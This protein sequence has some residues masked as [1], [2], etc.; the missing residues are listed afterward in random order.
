MPRLPAWL[1]AAAARMSR[2]PNRSARRRLALESL[3][4]REVPAAY[5]W[6]QTQ[7]G[8]FNWSDDANWDGDPG[9]PNAPGD[10]A[11]LGAAL[12]GNQVINF[13]T[14][15]TVGSLVVGSTGAGAYTIAGNG[16][17]LTFDGNGALATL[18]S[19]GTAGNAVLGPVVLASSLNVTNPD[20]DV[21]SIFGGITGTG[22]LSVTGPLALPN[23]ADLPAGITLAGTGP[24]TSPGVTYT[25]SFFD[26]AL[27]AFDSATG[28]TL[29]T[30]AAPYAVGGPLSGPAGLA[31]GPDGDLYVSNQ[32]NDTVIRFDQDTQA[33]STFLTAAQLAAAKATSFN[34]ADPY[35]PAGLA[36]GPTDGDL[37]V[38]R[39][40]GQGATGP[41]GVFRFD[42]DPG[43][44]NYA[45]TFGGVTDFLGSP[46]GVTFGNG[47]DNTSLYVSSVI[48][49]AGGLFD[50]TV[51]KVANAGT[52]P[53]ATTFVTPGAGGLQFAAGLAFDAAGNLYVADLAFFEEAGAG[54]GK[55][56]RY[57]AA[58]ANPVRFTPAP[59]SPGSLSLQFPSG[60]AFDADGRLVVVA[61][62]LERPPA[63][64]G[65]LYRYTTAGALD[66]TL[67]A[68]ARFPNTGTTGGGAT[69]SGITPSQVA[70]AAGDDL[71]VAGLIAPAG[72][73]AVGTLAVPSLT[74]AP[75]AT[76]SF[77]VRAGGNDRIT[78]TGTVALGNAD[79]SLVLGGFVPAP[80]SVYTIVSAAAV[81][82]TFFGLTNNQVFIGDGL[83]FRITYTATAV[84][85]TRV[86]TP[87]ITSAGTA[88]FYTN[89]DNTFVVTADGFPAPTI[90]SDPLPAGLTFAGGILSGTPTVAPGDYVITF[91]ATNDVGTDVETLTLTI[92]AGVA[93]DIT[94]ADNAAF[95]QGTGGTFDV[96]ATG[97]PA[98]TFAIPGAV[99]SGVSINPG[100][101]VVTVLPTTANGV[102]TLTIVASNGVGA[103]DT[104]TFTLTVGTVPEITSG[105][106]ATFYT[107][108]GNTFTVTADGFPTPTITSDPLPAGLT[109]AGGILS[110]TPT[111]APGDYVITFTATNAVGSDVE[112][113]TLTI[114]AGVAP[115]I[116]TLAAGAGFVQGT[117]GTFDVDAT[118]T[119]AA[120]FSLSNQPAGVTIDPVT[121]V[122]TV[123]TGVA[124][125][126]YNVTVTASNGV[127]PDD[128][129]VYALTVGT[130]P[131]VTSAG[132]ATFYTGAIASF[133]LAATG[134]PAPT[135]TVTG[136]L[137]PGITFNSTT[138]TLE[139][140]PTASGPFSVTVTATNAVGSDA[141]V[142]TITVQVGVAPMIT[143]ANSLLVGTATGGT[144]DVNATGNPA[145]TF[146]LTGAPAGV[147][148]DPVSGLLTV[149]AGLAVQTYTFD[150]TA[151][152][153]LGGFT[154]TFTLTVGSP[155][156]FTSANSAVFTAG[157]PGSFG[158]TASGS[159]ASTFAFTAGTL[160]PGITLSPSGTL[161]GTATQVGTFSATFTAT[162]GVNPPA[163][164]Q[165]TLT[166]GQGPVITSTNIATI[167]SAGGTFQVTATGTPA[168]TFGV[169]APPAGVTIDPTTG[170][171][172][173][174]A[175]TAAGVYNLTVT[176][177]NAV[178][179][180]N[181]VLNL[182]VT[183]A[184]VAVPADLPTRIGVGGQVNGG[185]ALF[186]PN[187]AGTYATAPTA[188]VNP[189][190]GLGVLVRS[191]VGDVNGD[192][193]DDTVVVTG[194]GTPVRFAVVSGTDNRTLLV[195]P[196][197][198]FAG[199]ESFT[200]GGFVSTGDLD[201]DGR[202]EVVLS[203]DQ[204]GG[205]R[206]TVFRLPAGGTLTVAA[207]FLGIDDANFRGG[208]RTAVGDVNGDGVPDLAVAAGFL[209]GPRVALFNGATLLTTRGKLVNDFF[210]F[211]GADAETL[212]NGAFVSIGD[213]TGDGFGDLIFGGGPGGAP[214]VFVLSGALVSAGNV[215]GA[216][217]APVANFFVANNSNDRGGAR[218]GVVD[219]NGDGRADLAVG[220][221]IGAPARVRVYLAQNVTPN[222]EPTPFQD[223]F[224]F[225]GEVLTDGIYVS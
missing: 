165:F 135:I 202:D 168:P 84:T 161:S 181:Q 55:V 119:P 9:F 62:G 132:T 14:P 98:P 73:G 59:G 176:A 187:A 137:P 140:I 130:V 17:A 217:A 115:D 195:P 123:G 35:A 88:T 75:S 122:I 208:A 45:G 199:S 110:G 77:D 13:T 58:G 113:L 151:T 139:G 117:G 146:S 11:N 156:Q 200:G 134:D 66:A 144:L 204:G 178:G 106:T 60:V 138:N 166:I 15:I 224:P 68:S 209:G 6:N 19:S 111:V 80:G 2:R 101:G 72:S 189:F 214:R 194:P 4:A 23:G 125:G 39:N 147:T 213:V 154:Q 219:A 87:E 185:T 118:G 180:A 205:P 95:V 27:Y 211:P 32:A 56:L 18:T 1:A 120:T 133:P 64:E 65:G 22:T 145:P 218:V 97:T 42:V 157:L 29:A 99:P 71:T 179:G 163:T 12:D 57:D 25:V 171:L 93:P 38:V 21:F 104:Q 51:T 50:G 26:S 78:S 16:N 203:P 155:P 33:F 112:T 225:T 24:I 94:T 175:G 40:A 67:V 212:R 41:G 103:D 54:E 201:G 100:T 79:P 30:L 223:L 183:A 49:A 76:Y 89:R 170:L 31:V 207:N 153:S 105:G 7:P 128:T 177:T 142:L 150:I 216:Q 34:T 159:P 74:L 90:T 92:V 206:V 107:G 126:V 52:A 173:V 121:G 53:A 162:N 164:Q 169:T 102:Y 3:E 69:L 192:G 136:T 143:T 215:A 124:N 83:Q 47:A 91:T 193:V 148:I 82:G 222:G 116:T 220:S 196:T 108:R 61:L 48:P 149:P 37:Y 190:S 131:E 46:A 5:T 70:L 28:A 86:S 36:F 141:E 167:G 114:I 191:S 81:T 198:A 96:D 109:F 174:A 188:T 85:I 197:A 152:N 186:D 63:T 20:T 158:L 127:T 172:T 184:P 182:T 160:P 10:V 8:A 210:A 44:G 221:G 43:T 129:Q